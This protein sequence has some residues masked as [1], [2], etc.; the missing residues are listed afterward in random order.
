M[1]ITTHIFPHLPDL[2]DPWKLLAIIMG[3]GEY[4]R[5]NKL[6]DINKNQWDAFENF[7]INLCFNR[8]FYVVGAFREFKGVRPFIFFWCFW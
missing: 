1:I 6:S 7:L 3:R 8:H 2:I 5:Y 4:T